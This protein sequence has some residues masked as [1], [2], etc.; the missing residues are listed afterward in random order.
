MCIRD[1]NYTDIVINE[2]HYNP[3]DVGLQDGDLFEFI[4]LKNKS[5]NPVNLTGLQFTDGI[6][7]TFPQGSI[8]PANSFIVLADDSLAFTNQYGF[9]PDGNYGSNLSNAGEQVVLSD[10]YG[11]PID[12]VLYDDTTPWVTGADG[13]GTSLGLIDSNSD[14]NIAANWS[15]QITGLSPGAE[16]MFC[17][18][19]L[20][21]LIHI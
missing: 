11:N 6:K 12:V 1:S 10:Y 20:L 2:I 18:G 15:T 5:N 9:S 16:N 21:S 13:N 3:A 14:N 19:S 4:E 8:L 7:Y 17:D